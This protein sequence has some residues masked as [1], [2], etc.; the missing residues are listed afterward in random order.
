MIRYRITRQAPEQAE[1][2]WTLL[3]DEESARTQA[4]DLASRN[5]TE[6]VRVYREDSDGSRELLLELN[7][8]RA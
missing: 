5:R 3:P 6:R 4:A 1:Q 2:T 8:P 7:R